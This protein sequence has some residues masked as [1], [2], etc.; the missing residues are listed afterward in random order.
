[1]LNPN[2]Q[3]TTFEIRKARK[4]TL[5]LVES[6]LGT[7]SQWQFIRSRLLQIF[8]KQGLESLL[9]DVEELGKEKN[10]VLRRSKENYHKN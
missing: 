8:G 4:L 10:N 1:M 5:D 3:R 9:I 2:E 6:F 7:H